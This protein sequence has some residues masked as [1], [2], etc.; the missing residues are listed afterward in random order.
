MIENEV[1]EFYL[2]DTYTRDII[3]SKYTAPITEAYFTVKTDN[4]YKEFV[5]QK[6]LNNGIMLVDEGTNE[7]GEYY[8]TYNL[9]LDAEDTDD[10]KPDL[11]YSFDFEIIS[12]GTS[13]TSI[14]QTIITG[15]FK[16]KN[17]TTKTYNEN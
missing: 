3:I 5:L 13:S 7:D 8:R 12:P 14:K 6:K 2:G 11:N 16:V 17:D 4:V 10:L 15:T 1:I 9:N